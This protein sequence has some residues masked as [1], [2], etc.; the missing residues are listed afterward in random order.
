[1]S[2]KNT[3]FAVA[4]RKRHQCWAGWMSDLVGGLQNRIER[5]DSATGLQ[6]ARQRAAYFLWIR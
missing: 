6:A 2:K 1:M 3:T 4:F 5:F